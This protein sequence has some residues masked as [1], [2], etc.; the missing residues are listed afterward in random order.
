MNNL[1]NNSGFKFSFFQIESVKYSYKIRKQKSNK[2]DYDYTIKISESYESVN[3]S[4]HNSP[5]VGEPEKLTLFQ[6]FTDNSRTFVAIK[7]FLPRS[8]KAKLILQNPDKTDGIY[9]INKKL[10]SG[11][12]TLVTAIRN[13]ELRLFEYYLELRAGKNSDEKKLQ[14]VS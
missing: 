2:A 3:E 9:L 5:S 7:F 11:F 6:N 12:H 8:A 1:S 10:K 13:E 4:I 14:Y